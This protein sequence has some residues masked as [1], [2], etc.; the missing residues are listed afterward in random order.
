MINLKLK[1]IIISG[2]KIGYNKPVFIIAE[3]GVNHNGHF[4]TALKLVDAAAAAG[5]DAVKFQTFKAGQ[6]VTTTGK[7]AKYQK[8]NI[9]KT[10]SQLDMLK[11]LELPENFYKPLITHCRKKKIIFLSTPHGGFDSVDFLERLNIAAFKIGSGDL[12]NL[13]LLQYAARLGKPMILGTGMSTLGEVQAAISIIKKAGNNK[14]IVLHCTTN[15]PCPAREVNLE[16]MRTM[17]AK[18]GVLVGYSDH[19]KGIQVPIMAVALGAC[20]IEKHF[21]LNRNMTGPDHKASLEPR[22]LKEMVKAIR[23]VSIILGSKI[24]S[25]NASERPLIKVARKSI[26]SLCKIKKGE[27]FTKNNTGI[28]RPGTGLAP[29]YYF[30]ILGKKAKVD[31][32]ADTFIMNNHYR[33]LAK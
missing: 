3:A 16:A 5:A 12:N 10:E 1:N 32:P 11:K 18:S 7:M 21:T 2:K 33:P 26:V 19:T 6:V 17:A 23:Q 15:Y 28:K 4:K 13:P 27:K 20:L 29:R 9:G 31:I 22:E 24:K 30:S 25:P 8:K 14:I